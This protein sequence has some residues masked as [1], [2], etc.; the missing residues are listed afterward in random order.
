AN[1]PV[2]VFSGV[3]S[4]GVP[5]WVDVPTPPGWAG[6]NGQGTA[7]CL[8]HLE[9]QLFPVESVGSRYVLTR[10]PV[11]STGSFREADVVRFVGAAEVANVTTSLPP[12]F[13]AF[14]LQPGEVRTTG[15]QDNV[16]ATGDKPFLL[17]QFL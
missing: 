3:E 16:V 14:T 11:R 9:E 5:Y 15:A 17:G 4:T 13:D 10:S 12:P 8:D 7:C 1:K 6:E 2:A